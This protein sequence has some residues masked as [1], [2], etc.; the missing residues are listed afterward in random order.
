MTML[1]GMVEPVSSPIHI[2][3]VETE[4]D[5]EKF[6]CDHLDCDDVELSF[7]SGLDEVDPEVEILST[8]IY[9]KI[10]RAFLDAHPMLRLVATRSNA[11]EHIDHAGCSERDVRVMNVTECGENTVAEY[12][13]ALILALSR[14]LR[15]AMDSTARGNFQ[16]SELRGIDLMGRMLGIV[17]AGRTGLHTIR[18]AKGFG[19]NVLAFDPQPNPATARDLGF[20]YVSFDELLE[21]S[22][23]ISIHAP[24]APDTRHL[25]DAGAFAKCKM[26]A[27]IIN[28][29]HG[30][31]ID[32]P[33]LLRALDEGRIAGAGLDV[34]E[35]ERV[36]KKESASIIGEQI[37]RN[38]R[39]ISSTDQLRKQ[40]PQR[41]AELRGVIQNRALISRPNVVVTPHIAYNSY[42]SVQR[43]LDTTLSSIHA[44]K[45]EI[46]KAR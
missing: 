40:S 38:L 22:D 37:V 33:A 36:M 31:L 19:M 45:E 9:S 16:Y 25:M 44:A 35:E 23:I 3:F 15:E 24:P 39:A 43:I 41:V 26:G 2:C 21:C 5:A 6:F 7:V 4:E 14:R 28:T 17:G 20:E 12:T 34:L 11:M 18:I 10:D 13:F 8:F 46:L 1:G 42:E 30:S 32:T 29:A 27:L